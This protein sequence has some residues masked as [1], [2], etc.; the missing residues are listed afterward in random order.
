MAD[1][2]KQ[3]SE[4]GQFAVA[5]AA[6]TAAD[7]VVSGSTAGGRLCRVH[8][9]TA[10]TVALQIFD[11]ATTSGAAGAILLYQ[12]TA[13]LNPGD[14]VNVQMPFASGLVPVCITNTPGVVL[15]FNKD[16]AYGR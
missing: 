14:S 13:A 12:T 1:L 9:T 7:A 10:G 2:V 8:C 15:T 16:T 11:S 6:G 3:H 4:G 5:I